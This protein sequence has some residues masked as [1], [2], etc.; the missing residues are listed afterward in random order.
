MDSSTATMTVNSHLQN[1]QSLGYATGQM[2]RM[3][4]SKSLSNSAAS[5]YSTIST[6]PS[7]YASWWT[8]LLLSDPFHV[9]VEALLVVMCLVLLLLQ[10]RSDWRFSQ[11][12]KKGAPTE[13]EID[14]LLKDW[15]EFGRRP[16]GGNIERNIGARTE[17][18]AG[19]LAG[20]GLVVEK[21][22]GSYIYLHSGRQGLERG[23]LRIV[24]DHSPSKL[25]KAVLNFATFDYLA[26]SSSAYLRGVAKSSLSVYGCGSCGPRGF[27]GTIDAH[28][29]VEDEMSSFLQTEGAILYSD[30]ASAVTSTVAAF[31]KRGDLLVVDEGVNE[32]LLVGVNLSRANVRY[33]R[34]NDVRDLRRTLEKVAAQDAALKRKGTDQRRFIIVE[35]VYR[36]W[37]TF[38]PLQQISNLKEEFNYRLIVDDSHGI[39]VLGKTGRG[40]LE[41]AGLNPMVHCEILTFSIE[42]ALG[43]VGG[44][45]VG[46]EEVVDHQRLSGAGYC[47]SA[48]APPFL[49]KVCVAS[50]KRLKGAEPEIVDGSTKEDSEDE[51]HVDNLRV[52]ELKNELKKRGLSVSGRKADLQARLRHSI[53]SA[54]VFQKRES[55]VTADELSG[56]HLVETLH[57]NI[58]SLYG[59][60]TDSSHEYANKLHDRLV[61]TSNPESPLIYLRLSDAEAYGRTRA[62]QS[63]IL[64]EVARHCLVEGEVAIVS[65]G[66]HVKKYL[67]LVPDPC[68]RIVAN[69]CQS[70]SDAEMLVQ[71]L[72]NAVECVFEGN[73]IE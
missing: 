17:N 35:G 66:G 3:L 33:F 71:A 50:V 26:T 69:V 18:E 44:M 43:S 60:L 9:A 41:H 58:A 8:N 36:N 23:S 64:D 65:T 2:L 63:E 37:G 10:R 24:G 56:P 4:S 62:E 47:F 13:K 40:S 49:S 14:E 20:T 7:L 57:E 29:E 6:I 21:I 70:R 5:A 27:Y 11:E 61:I 31:A 12:R 48:S 16:L 34:H 42:N 39:G 46:S 22:E 15:K 38:A 68:L 53:G 52:F 59:K 28:L 19:A 32:S 54:P 73:M 72:G 30:G 1:V 55:E 45:T 67:H 51:L 25:P